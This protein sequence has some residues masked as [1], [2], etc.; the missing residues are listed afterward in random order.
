MKNK[1]T[2]LLPIALLI[3]SYGPL[4][5]QQSADAREWLT[6]ADRSALLAE[7][8]D[9]LLF[10]SPANA[11]PTVDVNDMQQFQSM[12]G[13]GFALTGGSAQLLMRMEPGPRADLLKQLFAPT[14]TG[15][16]YL[17]VT[18]GASDMNERVY[19]YDD[20]AKGETDVDLAR[21]NLRPDR[22]EII[23]VLKQILAIN[24]GIKI[25]GS[26]WSAP[27]WMKT[28]DRVKGGHLKP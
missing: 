17:R 5:A 9:S 12:D 23:P 1:L 27:A 2:W 10:S 22:A 14:G 26:P 19:S 20:L 3:I 25:L 28:N 11:L 18:I 6:T 15:V 4:R 8:N 13:F 7:Q 24:P 16:S 21:F